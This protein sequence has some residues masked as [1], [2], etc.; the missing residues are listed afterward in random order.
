MNYIVA[1]LLKRILR[2]YIVCLQDVCVD[3][4]VVWERKFGKHMLKLSLEQRLFVTTTVFHHERNNQNYSVCG[5]ENVVCSK[6]S[7]KYSSER[8]RATVLSK[9]RGRLV[10]SVCS[11]SPEAEDIRRKLQKSI[12]D[13]VSIQEDPALMAIGALLRACT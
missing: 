5:L 2:D 10:P 4:C 13:I 6:A 1:P 3:F 7:H 11:S 12:D 8:C 9:G